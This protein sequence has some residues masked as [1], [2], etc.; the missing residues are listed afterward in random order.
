MDHLDG[1]VWM[2]PPGGGLEWTARPGEVEPVAADA[3]EGDLPEEL[4]RLGRR[5]QRAQPPG[6]ALTR[7]TPTGRRIHAGRIVSG[8]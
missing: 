8:R 4:L 6:V 7:R 3:P 5:R 2:R 1:Y